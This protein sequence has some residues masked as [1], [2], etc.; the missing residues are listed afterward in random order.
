PETTEGRQGYVHPNSIA[1]GVEKTTI[2]FIVRDF[3]AIRLEAH[4]RFLKELADRLQQ[5]EP[6]ARV[7]VEVKRS[8]RN[9]KEYLA[10]EPRVLA[11]A[12]EAVR[13]AGLTP[14]RLFIRGGTDGARLSEQGLPTPNLFTGMHDYHS[15]REWVSVQDLAASAATLVRLAEVWAEPE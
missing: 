10:T 13:R 1:G 4:E 6:R 11:K 2:H 9:M 15:V 14:K 12:E 7:S 3:D 5:S 8:Y